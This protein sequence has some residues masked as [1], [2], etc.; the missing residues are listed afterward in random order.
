MN[1]WLVERV[2][3][4]FYLFDASDYKCRY[5]LIIQNLVSTEKSKEVEEKLLPIISLP[6]GATVNILKHSFLLFFLASLLLP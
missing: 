3:L 1:T 5:T 2:S 6:R 4:R